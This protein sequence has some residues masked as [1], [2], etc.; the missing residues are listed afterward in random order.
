MWEGILGQVEEGV[1]VGVECMEP[2][3]PDHH[4]SAQA[5]RIRVKATR[6]RAMQDSLGQGLNVL[7]HH[8]VGD[9]SL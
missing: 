1:D 3:V 5:A 4:G 9:L 6:P 7:D 8:L 2:L